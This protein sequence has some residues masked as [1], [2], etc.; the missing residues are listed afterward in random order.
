[1]LRHSRPPARPAP[2]PTGLLRLTAITFALVL[3]AAAPGDAQ[4]TPDA[5]PTRAAGDAAQEADSQALNVFLDCQT[6]GCDRDFF[7]TEIGFVDWVRDRQDAQVHVI[8]T[9]QDSGAGNEFTVD[10]IGREGVLDGVV[11]QL[12]FASSDTD[13]EAERLDGLTRT[14]A[15]GLARFTQ[16][17]GLAGFQVA[18][19]EREEGGRAAFQTAEDPWNLWVFEIE[20]STEISEEQS[21]S[22]KSF[23][24]SLSA[25]RTTEEWNTE[26]ETRGW[27]QREEF[28]LNDSS[29]FVDKSKNWEVSGAVVNSIAPRW[30]L[31]GTAGVSGATFTNRDLSV[32]VGPALEWSYFPYEEATRRRLIVFYQ[33]ALEYNRYEEETLFLQ[34]EEALVREALTVS[35]RA[36][37]PWGEAEASVEGSHYFGHKG[38]GDG[39][40]FLWRLEANSE[41]QFRI[42]RGLSLD[43]EARGAWIRDQVFLPLEGASDEE[44]LVQRRQLATDFAW[45]LEVGLSFTFGSIYNAIV[46]NRF[47]EVFGGFRRGGR[48]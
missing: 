2:T 32:R 17:A 26:L 3:F 6:F 4:E 40:K 45:D 21:Q 35:Y 43:V 41:V 42:V 33:L 11:D 44:I 8:L 1:M 5:A 34:T 30:G 20:G 38:N 28:E 14:L 36:R 13:T 12:T 31:G 24:G 22:S 7:R 19:V 16:L 37:E 27:F 25:D 48:F 46:N 9:S 23:R 47:P 18:T 39:E 10:F 15:V 29:T